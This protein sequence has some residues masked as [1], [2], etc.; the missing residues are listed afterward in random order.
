MANAVPAGA[1]HG[2]AAAASALTDRRSPRF[3]RVRSPSLHSQSLAARH[4][5]L[6]DRRGPGRRCLGVRC[7]VEGGGEGEK[8]MGAVAMIVEDFRKLREAERIL[9]SKLKV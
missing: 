6:M 9:T 7:S 5:V 3:A 2:C 8:K 1:R 4:V